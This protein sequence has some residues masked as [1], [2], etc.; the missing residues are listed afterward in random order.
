MTSLALSLWILMGIALQ[1]LLALGVA[2]WRHWRTYQAL[3]ANAGAAPDKPAAAALAETAPRPA[4]WPGWRALRVTRK[5][6]ENAERSICSFYLSAEDAK[7]L[8][9]FLPGQFLT[10]RLEIATAAAAAPTVRC[11]SLSAA[12]RADYYR[13]S[14]KHLPAPAGSQAP[15]GL[16][17]TYLHQHIDVG[18]LLQARAPA[19]HFYLEPGDAP[20]VLIGGGIGITP[21]LSMLEDSLEKQPEREIWLF[22]GVRHA[23]E[24]IMAE[25]LHELAAT[26]RNFH[27]HWCFSAASVAGTPEDSAN[28]HPGR[29]DIRLLRLQLPLQPFQF[30]LCGPAAMLQSLVPALLSWGVPEQRIHYEAFGPASFTTH[31]ATT[32]TSATSKDDGIQVNFARSGQQLSWQAA[33][34]SLLEF[35]EA[36]GINV[37]SGCRAGGCGS[38]QTRIHAGEVSYRQTPD[39]DPEPGTCLLCVCEPKTPVTL[40]A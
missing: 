10:F 7:P 1:V 14:V 37:P 32:Q 18:S 2:F 38:C 19:G 23:G 5:V 36:N 31:S 17:S 16:A 15:A 22:Y 40:E 21:L 27:L 26:H 13:I 29:I 33:A 25:L 34:G 39:Y 3:R 12:P 30:Y 28:Y 20:V 35:A 4:A 9:P 11:Y 24:V 8:P 6:I